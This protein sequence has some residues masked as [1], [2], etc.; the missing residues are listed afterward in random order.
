MADA[1]VLS[2]KYGVLM[3]FHQQEHVGMYVCTYL[4]AYDTYGRLGTL[5]GCHCRPLR[6]AKP[7]PEHPTCS[8]AWMDVIHV[9][10]AMAMNTRIAITN[11]QTTT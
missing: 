1:W 10:L 4:T 7:N 8:A 3:L 6:Q 2:I 9:I 5:V 11:S